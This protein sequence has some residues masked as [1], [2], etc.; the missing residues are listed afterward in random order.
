MLQGWKRERIVGYFED[1]QARVLEVGPNDSK[2]WWKKVMD[3]I[4]VVNMELGYCTTGPIDTGHSKVINSSVISHD[5][6]I[7]KRHRELVEMI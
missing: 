1:N 4:Y 5:Q 6:Y 7:R 3:V 2:A